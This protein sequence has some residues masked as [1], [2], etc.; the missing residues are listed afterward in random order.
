MLTWWGPIRHCLFSHVFQS[1]GTTIMDDDKLGWVSNKAQD[2]KKLQTSTLLLV[3]RNFGDS[4]STF[5][6]KIKHHYACSRVFLRSSYSTTKR[7][8]WNMEIWKGLYGA[9]NCS[10]IVVVLSLTRKG[11]GSIKTL[12]ENVMVVGSKVRELL[13]HHFF[14]STLNILTQENDSPSLR[15][16]PSIWVQ[17]WARKQ[18]SGK[19][20]FGPKLS[21]VNPRL[22]LEYLCKSLGK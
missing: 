16:R 9:D 7:S 5:I 6:H 18:R 4:R 20:C 12:L 19:G 17:P 3:K 1:S 2:P 21:H 14:L 15:N 11:R 22:G 8:P 10:C 13:W